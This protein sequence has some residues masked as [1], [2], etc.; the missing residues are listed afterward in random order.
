MNANVNPLIAALERL[1]GDDAA[2]YDTF[3][4]ERSWI[5]AF[6]NR[7]HFALTIGAVSESYSTDES[8]GDLSLLHRKWIERQHR[9]K[10]A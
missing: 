8:L 4:D 1:T 10:T 9:M 2:D 3:L 6:E 5:D 7:S